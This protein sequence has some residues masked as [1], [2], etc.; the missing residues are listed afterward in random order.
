[1]SFALT[2]IYQISWNIFNLD[3]G[4]SSEDVLYQ[5]FQAKLLGKRELLVGFVT[6]WVVHGFYWKELNNVKFLYKVSIL[7]F[8]N[9]TKKQEIM[10]NIF[11]SLAEKFLSFSRYSNYCFF[12]SLFLSCRSLLNLKGETEDNFYGVIMCLNRSL[13]TLIVSCEGK[14]I[15]YWKVVAIWQNII[16][17]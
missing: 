9:F 2:S 17:G 5:N 16:W 12:F 15:R 8:Y 11:F 4:V 6:F 3:W 13:N 10:W 14:R 7:S 1:M